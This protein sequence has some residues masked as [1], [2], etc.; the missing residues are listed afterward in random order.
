M[1]MSRNR[2]SKGVLLLI[3]SI[4]IALMAWIFYPRE[5]YVS[6]TQFLFGTNITIEAYSRTPKLCEEHINQAFQIMRNMDESINTYSPTGDLHQ[7]NTHLNQWVK[8]SDETRWLLKEGKSGKI[9][10]DGSYDIT[11]YPLLKAWGFNALGKSNPTSVPSKEILQEALSHV[12]SNKIVFKGNEAMLQTPLEGVDVGSILKGYAI[13]KAQKYLLSV[14]ENH[15][16]ITAVSSIATTGTKPGNRPWEIG[17][18]NPKNL[19]TY[20]GTLT[21]P[22][23][24]ALG[25]SGNFENYLMI[26]GKEYSHILDARTGMPVNYMDMIVLVSSNCAQGDLYSTILFTQPIDKAIA[27]INA[28]PGMEGL[29]VDMNGKIYYSKYMSR[30]FKRT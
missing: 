28:T 17:V 6:E 12:D 26:N 7:L 18:V 13:E 30:Y 22:G 29:I 10:S 15:A 2:M 5:H 21:L 14:K 23:N 1:K 25:V 3:F 4:F 24:M 11:L 16:L 27:M 20:I 9:I 8:I 19:K